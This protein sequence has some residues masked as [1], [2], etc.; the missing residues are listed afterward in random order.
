MA[1]PR[2]RPAAAAAAPLAPL[3]LLLLAALLALFAQPAAANHWGYSTWA[4][5]SNTHWKKSLATPLAKPVK[6]S[7][8]HVSGTG[9]FVYVAGSATD[10]AKVLGITGWPT[11][12]STEHAFFAVYTSAGLPVR[13]DAIWGSTTTT[14][15]MGDMA[16]Y[17]P[18]SGSDDYVYVTGSTTGTLNVSATSLGRYDPYVVRYSVSRTTGIITRDWIVQLGT[19]TIHDFGEAICVNTAGTM[20]WVGGR[21]GSIANSDV[22]AIQYRTSDAYALITKTPTQ[23]TPPDSLS[24]NTN[25]HEGTERIAVSASGQV[26]QAVRT[27]Y[28]SGTQYDWSLMRMDSSDSLLVKW[29]AR[30][31]SQGTNDER[32]VGLHIATV[33]GEEMV[34]VLGNMHIYLSESGPPNPPAP[35]LLYGG[36]VSG[37]S[38]KIVNTKA[39]LAR[40]FMNGTLDYEL[41]NLALP[42]GATLEGDIATSLSVVGDTAYVSGALLGAAG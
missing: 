8:V 20:V 23:T 28:D 22:F 27:K 25:L 30:P 34:F 11:A 13:S 18:S 32:V 33:N 31:T 14:E 17:K 9:A 37:D 21:S 3:L 42:T 15:L 1:A 39:F 36:A 26:Y 4:E 7:R 2:R 10:P 12:S 41:K 40:Y 19:S 35:V 16:V 6:Y 29:V 38:A 24:P 5:P